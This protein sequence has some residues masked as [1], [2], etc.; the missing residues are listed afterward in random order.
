MGRQGAIVQNR[1][2]KQAGQ[3]WS[4]AGGKSTLESL[5]PRRERVKVGSLYAAAGWLMSCRCGWLVGVM[6]VERWGVENHPWQTRQLWQKPLLNFTA[7]SWDGIFG[8]DPGKVQHPPIPSPAEKLAVSWSRG[9]KDLSLGWSLPFTQDN[10]FEHTAKMTQGQLWMSQSG[11]G[12]TFTSTKYN[13]SEE[14]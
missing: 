9:L 14:T 11:P 13:N 2:E 3:G 6:Q 4:K 5:A 12:R 1:N 7:F 8:G 10:E